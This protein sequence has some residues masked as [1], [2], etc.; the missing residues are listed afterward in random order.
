MKGNHSEAKQRYGDGWEHVVIWETLISVQTQNQD[1]W[2]IWLAQCHTNDEK[3]FFSF[4]LKSRHF[5]PGLLWLT[6]TSQWNCRNVEIKHQVFLM[7]VVLM[8]EKNETEIPVAPFSA[9]NVL[10]WLIS[11]YGQRAPR[12]VQACSWRVSRWCLAIWHLQ[13]SSGASDTKC[14]TVA[15]LDSDGS[16]RFFFLETPTQ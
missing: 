2:H 9:Y 11:E 10:T 1:L 6:I 3:L 13:P 8:D 15:K 14:S 12:Y 5:S 16:S 7:N 4:Q